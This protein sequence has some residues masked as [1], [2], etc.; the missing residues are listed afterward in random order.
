[1]TNEATFLREPAV[2]F[3]RLLP[4]TINEAW[5]LLVDSKRLS[6]WYG[7]GAMIEERPGGAVQMMN[8]HIRGIV[9]QWQPPHRLAYTWNVFAPG[10]ETSDYPESYLTFELVPKDSSTRLTLTHLPVLERFEKQN[11]MGWHTFLDMIEAAAKGETVEERSVYM[12]RNAAAYGIDLNNL[13]R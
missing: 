13:T 7:E 5:A 6:G 8:S 4:L 2:R 9:T 3:E 1:M 12:K 10:Q 11:A